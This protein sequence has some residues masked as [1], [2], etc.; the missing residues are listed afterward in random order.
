MQEERG[1][2]IDI[3]AIEFSSCYLVRDDHNIVIH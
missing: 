2:K 1:I 3:E